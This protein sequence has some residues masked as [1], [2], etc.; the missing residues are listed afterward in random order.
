M[1]SSTGFGQLQQYRLYSHMSGPKQ[2]VVICLY[3]QMLNNFTPVF[4]VVISMCNTIP[5]TVFFLV[6][7]LPQHPSI[8]NIHMTSELSKY[9]CCWFETEA[10]ASLVPELECFCLEIGKIC[11]VIVFHSF[12]KQEFEC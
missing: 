9:C 8:H 11:K 6:Q 12:S 2:R 7:L 3:K 4:S 5:G 10:F 1:L